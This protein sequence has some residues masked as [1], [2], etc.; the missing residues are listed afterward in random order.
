MVGFGV[1]VLVLSGPA[2]VVAGLVM[3]WVWWMGWPASRIRNLVLVWL[4]CVL[5][6]ALVRS[7]IEAWRT[8]YER[9]V[10]GDWGGLVLQR[11]LISSGVVRRVGGSG[12]RG[13]VVGVHG[14]RSTSA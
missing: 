3:W 8:G 1:A 2:L 5:A 4:V 13:P 11:Q 7:P 9:V 6:G 14:A 10:G 12:S